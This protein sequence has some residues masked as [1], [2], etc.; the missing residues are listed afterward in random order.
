MRN[1]FLIYL[2]KVNSLLHTHTQIPPPTYTH[3]LHLGWQVGG[4]R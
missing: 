1:F 2:H 3:T 4:Q